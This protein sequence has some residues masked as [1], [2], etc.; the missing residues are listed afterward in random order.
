ME[1]TEI[2]ARFSVKFIGSRNLGGAAAHPGALCEQIE[3]GTPYFLHFGS[4]EKE[5]TSLN[6]LN[7][8]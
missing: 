7:L 8:L 4:V 2:S 6:S 5:G 1:L 3:N